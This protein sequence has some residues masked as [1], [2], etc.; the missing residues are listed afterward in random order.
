MPA[1]LAGLEGFPHHFTVTIP[2]YGECLGVRAGLYPEA[3]HSPHSRSA[4]ADALA[5]VARIVLDEVVP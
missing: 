4:S 1:G 5:C 3:G 2:A